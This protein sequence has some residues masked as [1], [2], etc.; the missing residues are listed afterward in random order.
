MEVNV[1]EGYINEFGNASYNHDIA[2]VKLD[3]PAVIGQYVSTHIFT[4]KK[5][6]QN[7]LFLK[8]RYCEII[9]NKFQMLYISHTGV[10]VT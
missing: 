1:Q 4:E 10:A 7:E 6:Q 5:Q 3:R 2:V 9:A 8:A